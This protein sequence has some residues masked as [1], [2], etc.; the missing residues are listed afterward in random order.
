MNNIR[1]ICDETKLAY[2]PLTKDQKV[3]VDKYEANKAQYECVHI[4]GPAGSGKTFIALYIIIQTLLELLK[5]TQEKGQ[6]RFT[7]YVMKC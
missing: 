4:D 1:L 5:K 6:T 2:D 3:Y 7:F